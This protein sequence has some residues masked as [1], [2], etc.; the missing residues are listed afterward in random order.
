MTNKTFDPNKYIEQSTK[1]IEGI[2]KYKETLDSDNPPPRD[3]KL[4]DSMKE[5]YSELLVFQSKLDEVIVVD[6]KL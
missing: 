6:E 3:E 4:V 1:V 5:L 2:R